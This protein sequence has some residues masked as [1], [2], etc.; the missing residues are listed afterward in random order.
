M[1][2][3]YFLF[4]V[5]A[6]AYRLVRS[7]PLTTGD[8]QQITTNNIALYLSA[9]IVFGYGEFGTHLASITGGIFIFMLLFALLNYVL[10]SSEIVLQQTLAMQAVILLSMFIGFNWSGL[11]VTLLW[12]TLAVVLFMLGIYN[13]R[14]W[15]RLAAI[16]LLAT[17]LGKLVIFDSSKFTTLQKIIAY[18]VIGSL[19]LVLSFLY[20]KYGKRLFQ[21]E[22]S[23]D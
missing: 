2:T 14:S 18:I 5:N 4:T 17:T 9:L 7:E 13:H 1:G 16:L 19:L 12:V 10:F 11:T 22:S 8:I 21:N 23:Q 3:F 6:L 20:Q 15:P